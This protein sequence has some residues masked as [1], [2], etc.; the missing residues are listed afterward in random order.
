M[1]GEHAHQ[2]IQNNLRLELLMMIRKFI[3]IKEYIKQTLVKSVAVHSMNTF[4]V[5]SVI[6]E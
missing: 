2:S 3:E 6:L 4:F 5:F 1:S